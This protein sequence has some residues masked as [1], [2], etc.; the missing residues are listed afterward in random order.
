MTAGDRPPGAAAA[1]QMG[2]AHHVIRHGSV[3]SLAEAAVAPGV[4]PTDV[5]KTMVVRRG[6]G[7]NRLSMPDAAPT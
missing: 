1:D 6:D 4:E 5:V 3:R 7:D 2:L